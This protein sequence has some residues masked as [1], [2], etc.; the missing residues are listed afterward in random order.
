MSVALKAVQICEQ[1]QPGI[2]SRLE[3]DHVCHFYSKSAVILHQSECLN[4]S[5]SH[6]KPV[7]FSNLIPGQTYLAFMAKDTI[8]QESERFGEYRILSKNGSFQEAYLIVPDNTGTLKLGYPGDQ[9]CVNIC[10]CACEYV[11]VCVCVCVYVC[12]A[13]TGSC[14]TVWYAFMVDAYQCFCRVLFL[15]LGKECRGYSAMSWVHC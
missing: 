1:A 8:L 11:C 15:S 12:V 3:M 14:Q 7:A 13:Y 4:V 5:Q 9:V 10:V 2:F 6:E